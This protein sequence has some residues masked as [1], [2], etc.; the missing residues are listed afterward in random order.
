MSKLLSTAEDHSSLSV[1]LA[2]GPDFF[3]QHLT[4]LYTTLRDTGVENETLETLAG[5][6]RTPDLEGIKAEL[7][8]A[9]ESLLLQAGELKLTPRAQQ[10]LT[11]FS[12]R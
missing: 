10:L 11:E 2:L 1:V 5:K 8:R 6:V 12:A 3:L 7:R 4:G 9:V